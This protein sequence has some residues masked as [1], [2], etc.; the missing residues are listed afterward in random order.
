MTVPLSEI[1]EGEVEAKVA[2]SANGYETEFV[3]IAKIQSKSEP[4]ISRTSLVIFINIGVALLV[5]FIGGLI[6]QRKK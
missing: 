4:A 3:T 5:L 2:A 6:Y 1:P